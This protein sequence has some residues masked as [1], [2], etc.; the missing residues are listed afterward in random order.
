VLELRLAWRNVWRNPR[1]T[2][3]TLAATVFAVLLVVTFVAMAAGSHEKMIED[4]VRLHSGHLALSA[5]GY[6][7]NRTLDYYVDLGPELVELV[8]ETEGIR[9]WAPRVLSFALLSKDAAT[10]GVAL[11]GVDPER[12]STVT[13]LL[14]RV[15]KGRFVAGSLAREIV[16]GRRLARNLDAEIGDEVL[17]YSAAYSLE[18]AY[19]LFTIVGIANLMEPSLDR[20]TALISLADA[21]DFFVYGDRVSEV[22]I[23]A[24]DADAAGPVAARL[25]SILAGRAGAPSVHPWNELMPELEQFVILDDA[26]MYLLLVVLVVVVGFGILN[27]LL[28]S[29][30]ERSRELGVV[31]ALGLRP[32]AVFRVVYWESMM[33]AAV[34]LLLGLALAIPLVLYFEAHPIPLTGEAAAGAMDMFGM[35]PVITWKLKP[36]NPIGSVVTILGVAA[37]AA[38]YPAFKASRSRPVDALRSL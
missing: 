36:R 38:L 6:L 32:G 37:L 1:R 2:G 14:Q 4:S 23:L 3:I 30:L 27:T 15:E 18:T 34:G 8:E 22:A 33:I 11:L 7:E 29:V 17:L 28:M 24:A 9:G 26:G 25:L 35:E 10:Q 16:L 21:Q 5:P 20:S 31:L 13:T 12:E 19:E